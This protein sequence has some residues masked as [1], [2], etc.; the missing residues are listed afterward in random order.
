MDFIKSNE[1]YEKA[2]IENQCQHPFQLNLIKGEQLK[3]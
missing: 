1:S 2:A 3:T